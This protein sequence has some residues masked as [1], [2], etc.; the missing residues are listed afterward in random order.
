MIFELR[1]RPGDTENSCC[2]RNGRSAEDRWDGRGKFAGERCCRFSGWDHLELVGSRDPLLR[3]RF[4]TGLVVVFVTLVV[5]SYA[6]FDPAC[7]V[8]YSLIVAASFFMVNIVL[9]FL[10][11]DLSQCIYWLLISIGDGREMW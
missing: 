6:R 10:P 7:S 3:V 2:P 1:L 11:C 8:L 5:V 4:Y 9:R